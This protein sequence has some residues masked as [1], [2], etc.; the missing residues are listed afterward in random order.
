VEYYPKSNR[1]VHFQW[2]SSQK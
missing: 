2:K 1:V